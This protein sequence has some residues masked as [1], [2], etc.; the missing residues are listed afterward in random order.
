MGTEPEGSPSDLRESWWGQGPETIL[1]QE[2]MAWRVSGLESSSLVDTSSACS[3]LS[4]SFVNRSP[5]FPSISVVG[6]GLG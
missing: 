1:R 5:R 3:S 6:I 2:S 4:P